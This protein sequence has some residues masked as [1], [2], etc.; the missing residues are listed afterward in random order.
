VRD[1]VAFFRQEPREAPALAI[2]TAACVAI[3]VLLSAA[4][5]VLLRGETRGQRTG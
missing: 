1:R 5:L 4:G 2:A 3:G